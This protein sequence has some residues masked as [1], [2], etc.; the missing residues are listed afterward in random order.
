MGVNYAEVFRELC[1]ISNKSPRLSLS[2]D[3][4]VSLAWFNYSIMKKITYLPQYNIN[5]MDQQPIWSQLLL[6]YSF[7]IRQNWSYIPYIIDL[8]LKLKSLSHFSSVI[9]SYLDFHDAGWALANNFSSRKTKP[10]SHLIG[11][12]PEPCLKLRDHVNK[13]SPLS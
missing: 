11:W 9:S 8:S 1:S 10:A 13:T 12:E 4:M 6:S 7:L 2:P 5:S 3:L